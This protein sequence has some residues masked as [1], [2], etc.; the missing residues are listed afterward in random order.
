MVITSARTG[1][2]KR[3]LIVLSY[4]RVTVERFW[5]GNRIYCNL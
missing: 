1:K 2:E 3:K 4:D 5:I